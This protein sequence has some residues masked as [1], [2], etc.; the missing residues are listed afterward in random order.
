MY[1]IYK[2][3]VIII[4]TLLHKSFILSTCKIGWMLVYSSTTDHYWHH[5]KHCLQKQHNILIKICN[6]RQSYW[7]QI[8]LLVFHKT[9]TVPS[10]YSFNRV[11]LIITANNEDTR[12]TMRGSVIWSVKQ[13]V[14]CSTNCIVVLL[15]CT[16][17]NKIIHQQIA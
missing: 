9:F 3:S 12:I 7:V 11:L 2:L 14:C 4:C 15:F 17:Q 6:I 13:N 5:M 10:Q 1:D 16:Y 8:S